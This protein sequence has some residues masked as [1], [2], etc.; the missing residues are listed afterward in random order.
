MRPPASVEQLLSPRPRGPVA[1]RA[2]T[3]HLS[4][5]GER[6]ALASTDAA[7][8]FRL[9]G[10]WT[11]TQPSKQTASF[12]QRRTEAGEEGAEGFPCRG[13]TALLQPFEVQ[14]SSV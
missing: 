8:G 7:C 6:G 14:L 3:M 13:Q 2:V 12:I 10:P 5:V 9:P 4:H 1:E 11:G